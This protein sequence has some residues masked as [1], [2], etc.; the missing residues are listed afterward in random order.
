M[1][2]LSGMTRCC[3]GNVGAMRKETWGLRSASPCL[4]VRWT[5]GLFVKPVRPEL[6]GKSLRR[7][8]PRE[9]SRVLTRGALVRRPR[10]PP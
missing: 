5:P 9:L 2:V 10:G 8:G 3:S 4:W 7:E 1:N 6:S